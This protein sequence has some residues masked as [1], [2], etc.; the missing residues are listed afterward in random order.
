[1]LNNKSVVYHIKICLLAATVIVF[2][3]LTPGSMFMHYC[4]SDIAVKI[5]KWL[6]ILSLHYFH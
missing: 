1:M 3:A 4:R 2:L 6:V 5:S